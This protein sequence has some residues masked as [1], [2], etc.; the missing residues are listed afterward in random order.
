VEVLQDDL[1]ATLYA[2]GQ[3]H[4]V[5][6]LK[7]TKTIKAGDQLWLDYGKPFW[8]SIDVF[9]NGMPTAFKTAP[10]PHF[11][12]RCVGVKVAGSAATRRCRT[13][14]GTVTHCNG[15]HDLAKGPRIAKCLQKPDAAGLQLAL[16]DSPL[17]LYSWDRVTMN[18]YNLPRQSCLYTCTYISFENIL[19]ACAAVVG[20]STTSR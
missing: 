3:L 13:S 4:H 5:L 11:P 8:T 2:T 12:R 10:T 17:C 18:R 7:T 1:P 6:S 16:D 15:P 20:R 9:D 19:N 14:A